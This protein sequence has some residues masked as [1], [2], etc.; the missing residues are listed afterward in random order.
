[1]LHHPYDTPLCLISNV[2]CVNHLLLLR[3]LIGN[4][5]LPKSSLAVTGFIHRVTSIDNIND[6]SHK[7]KLNSSTNYLT[8]HMYEVQIT[9]QFEVKILPLILF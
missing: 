7:W 5:A 6:K 2:Q 8:D 1:M 9:P 3:I 4:T